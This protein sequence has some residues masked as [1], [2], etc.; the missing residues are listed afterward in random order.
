MAY[1]LS[2]G[3]AQVAPFNQYTREEVCT[4]H[5]AQKACMPAF[6]FSIPG[7][8]NFRTALDHLLHCNSRICSSLRKKVRYGMQRKLQWLFQEEALLGCIYVQPLLYHMRK[9]VNLGKKENFL[10]VSKHLSRCPQESCSRLRRS[11]L[12]TVRDAVSPNANPKDLSFEWKIGNRKPSCGINAL[13]T[14]LPPR[15]ISINSYLANHHGVI[16]T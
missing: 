12:L 8:V 15:F 14:L 5:Q 2:I 10:V 7:Q 1:S 13:P 16:S 11:I 6:V 9:V 4:C 3:L